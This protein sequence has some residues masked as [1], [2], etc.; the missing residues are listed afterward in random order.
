VPESS[1][2]ARPLMLSDRFG[3]VFTYAVRHLGESLVSSAHTHHHGWHDGIRASQRQKG[4]H[5][6]GQLQHCE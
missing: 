2:F 6:N 4:R 5:E 3:E 1:A